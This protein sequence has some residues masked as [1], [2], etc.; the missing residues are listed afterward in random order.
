MELRDFIV[1]PIVIVLI[2]SGAYFLRPYVTDAVNRRYFIPALMVRIV[3]ALSLGFIY[4]FYYDGGDT[5]NYHQQGSRIIWE[6]FIE[7]PIDGLTLIFG[8]A[9]DE[10]EMY[11][12]SSR[13]LFFRDS[14]SYFVVRIA[15]FFDLLTFS[16]YSATAVLFSVISSVG[17]WMLFLTFY[18]Q[19]PHLHR[20]IAL[21]TFFIPSVLVSP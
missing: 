15:A 17:M 13:I 19:Y 11:Q 7:N 4:Q 6:S 8:A 3:G 21:A 5:F 12:Y 20:E 9:N 16:S 18:K 10:L 1:T 14:N 2:C